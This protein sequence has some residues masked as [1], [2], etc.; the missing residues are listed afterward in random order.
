MAL[1]KCSEC[2]REVSD[3]AA[4][5][6]GCGAPIEK[7][8]NNGQ[9]M[10]S[11]SA[12]EISPRLTGREKIK[13]FLLLLGVMAI[14]LIVIGLNSD[15]SGKAHYYCEQAIKLVAKDPDSV[16]LPYVE[17][18]GSKDWPEYEWSRFTKMARMK[19]GLGIE[20]AVTVKCS[21]SFL[22]DKVT[23]LEIDGKKYI[24]Y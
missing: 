15:G 3:K 21:Y 20:T 18:K 2:S 4:S 10:S 5:C 13:M 8:L 11:V 9:N 16:D 1:V 19:N 12:D 23:S 7:K 22:T 24:G 6:V 14:G 17:N